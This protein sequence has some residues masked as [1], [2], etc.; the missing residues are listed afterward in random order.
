MTAWNIVTLG[1]GTR[2]RLMPQS[3]L[4]VITEADGHR[5]CNHGDATVCDRTGHETIS[6]YEVVPLAD[7][8]TPK[9]APDDDDE[10]GPTRGLYGEHCIECQHIVHRGPCERCHFCQLEALL[11]EAGPRAFDPD[12]LEAVRAFKAGKP[13][14]IIDE[15][16]AEIVAEGARTAADQ[17]RGRAVRAEAALAGFRN[18]VLA[19]IDAQPYYFWTGERSPWI[20]RGPLRAA[21]EQ[22]ET[23]T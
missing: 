20:K 13:H 6:L 22:M 5:S 10:G 23:P 21:V 17:Q 3:C 2:A 12:V 7:T 16:R 4:N 14:P 1:D 15:L 19:A 9:A 11:K 8:E 18:D